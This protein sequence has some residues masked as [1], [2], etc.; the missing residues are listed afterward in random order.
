M[1]TNIETRAR[2]AFVL[3]L[4]L[5]GAAGLA[6]YF[7]ASSRYTTFQIHT[8]DPVSGLIVDAPVEFHGVEVGKVKRIELTHSHAVSILLSVY[9]EAPVT[10]AT[11]ATITG[12]GL[13]TRGFTGYVYVSLE[14]VGTDARPLVAPPG[15]PFPLIP[16]APS[17]SVNL[18]TT[19]NQLSQNVQ[20]MTDLLQ[21]VL[22]QKTI[23]SLKQSVDS[24]QRVTQT[25]AANNE[26]LSS[27]I[28]H[29]ER[30]STQ[31][32]PLLQSSND[33]V[34]ALQTQILPEAHRT[35]TKL[36]NLASTQFEPL[37]QSSNDTVKALQT[38][39]LPEA[40]RTLVKLDNLSTS[41]SDV[42]TKIKRDPSVLIRGGTPPSPGP[43]ET[44]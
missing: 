25:L 13:A 40:Y 38:Q 27:I 21:S 20:L 39:I 28:L 37:L 16:T 26:K 18:D 22:D 3:F 15:R 8:Q 10:T 11:V 34:R 17:R 4:L 42:V 33:T 9:R 31:F 12:R 29:A 14:D 5:C 6:W 36:D 32:E 35:L 1:K 30:A 19:I 7:V 2:V 24:L 43:G 44:R 41:L 23:A